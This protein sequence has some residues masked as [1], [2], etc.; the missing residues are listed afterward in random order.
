MVGACAAVLA[1]GGFGA[2][3]A[4]AE[5]EVE[6]PLTGLP[7]IGRCVKV[8]PGTGKFNLSQCVGRDKDGGDGSY[9]W[10]PGPSSI[11]RRPRRAPSSACGRGFE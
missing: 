9:D 3:T 8:T 4:F 11:S 10:K 5:E 1:L 6:Y 7:E 2:G